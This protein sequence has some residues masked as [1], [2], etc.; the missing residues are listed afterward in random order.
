MF[1]GEL[2]ERFVVKISGSADNIDVL[3]SALDSLDLAGLEAL[4]NEGVKA[5]D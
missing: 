5:T 2:G 3:R 4:K 1:L